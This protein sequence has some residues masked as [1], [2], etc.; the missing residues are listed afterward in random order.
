[1]VSH[2]ADDELLAALS[3]DAD[4]WAG[5]VDAGPARRKPDD[6]LARWERV[7]A[8]GDELSCF[9]DCVIAGPGNP[10]SAAPVTHRHG[11]EAVL[12]VTLEPGFGGLPGRAHGGIVA[13]LFDE[14]MGFALFM[15]G[16][17]AYTAWLRVD[18][19]TPVEVGAPL[20]IRARLRER[21][22]RKFV[23]EAQMLLGD[24]RLPGPT[25]EALYVT[26]RPAA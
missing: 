14:V 4:R 7:R 26:P 9:G 1:M 3:A 6:G 18:Y 10:L 21:E 13:S 5:R 24:E 16:W 19:R 17:P 23:V 8:D 15:D 20:E 2:E 12:R 11:D 25:A 22:G